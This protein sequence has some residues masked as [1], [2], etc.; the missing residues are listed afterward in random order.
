MWGRSRMIASLLYLVFLLLCCSPLRAQETAMANAAPCKASAGIPEFSVPQ[1]GDSNGAPSPLLR[2]Q[3][4]LVRARSFSELSGKFIESR[5]FRSSADYFRTRF[6]FSRFILLRP[7]HY[8]VEINPRIS[9]SGPSEQSV[10][11]ILAHELVHIDR[12]STGNRIRLFGLVRLVSRGYTA[13]FE[14]STDLEAIRRGY[15]PGLISFREW[16]Y[17]N[18]PSAALKLKRRNYFSPEEI[19]A[20]LR[21]SQAN[22]ALPA[23]WKQ[24]VPMNLQEILASPAAASKRPS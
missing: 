2:Q 23:Y 11:A 10:C 24:Y 17:L 5:T 13:R 14:R 15:G 19:S 18:I 9:V 7:M 20:I 21:L 22:P 3:F 12:M 16:V 1:R 6:S 4:D 8:F